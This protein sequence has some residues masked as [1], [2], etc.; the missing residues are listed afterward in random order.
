MNYIQWMEADFEALFETSILLTQHSNKG[1]KNPESV[2]NG[3]HFYGIG[4]YMI[5]EL[6]SSKIHLQQSYEYR[7]YTIGVINIMNQIALVILN[8]AENNISGAERMIKVAKTEIKKKGSYVYSTILDAVHAEI[9]LAKNEVQKAL[10]NLKEVEQLPLVPFTNFYVPQFTLVKALI[11]ANDV[12][13]R[14]KAASL[15]KVYLD[16]AKKTHNKLFEMKFMAL[17]ALQYYCE[18]DFTQALSIMQ[19]LIVNTKTHRLTRV[20][21]DC[22]PI[23]KEL[24]MQYNRSIKGDSYV[25]GLIEAFPLIP[26]KIDLTAREMDIL[27]MLNLSNKEIAEKLYI[28]EKTV[29]RHSNGIFKKLHVKNRREALHKAMELKLV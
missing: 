4:K 13:S 21:V 20:F 5:N 3:S 8:L 6:E 1:N 9:Y 15:L 22:G 19:E 14:A 28:A 7:H 2:A 12:S 26:D 10:N 11:Y 25:H 24:L 27:P 18:K 23:M 29:K 16:L 17:R